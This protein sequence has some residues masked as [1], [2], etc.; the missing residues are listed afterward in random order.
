M[1][2]VSGADVCYEGTQQSAKA[3]WRVTR[4]TFRLSVLCEVTFEQRS[5]GSEMGLEEQ[6]YR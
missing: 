4:G 5:E 1:Y 6:N 2:T 3:E